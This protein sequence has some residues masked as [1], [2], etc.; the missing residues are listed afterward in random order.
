MQG[1]IVREARVR[2]WIREWLQR[3]LQIDAASIAPDRP[4]FS[5]G[6]DSIHAMMLVGDLEEML[7]MRLP[8]TLVWDQPTEDM[9]VAWLG[10]NAADTALDA[11]AAADLLDRIETLPDDE[12]DRLLAQHDPEPERA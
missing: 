6:M 10:Q 12:V 7:A 4:L 8:P 9:L 1:S 2:A 11:V 3:E 5:Y